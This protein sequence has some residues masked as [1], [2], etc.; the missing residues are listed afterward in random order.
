M[1]RASLA[2]RIFH[3]LLQLSTSMRA[4]PRLPHSQILLT[5]AGTRPRGDLTDAPHLPGTAMTLAITANIQSSLSR[6]AAARSLEAA[7]ARDPDL[8]GLQE[9]YVGRTDML[10]IVGVS[11]WH[12]HRWACESR[13]RDQ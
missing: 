8:L 1:P 2:E 11:T 3:Q 4:A 7:L 5:Y 12:V 13:R 6:A 10:A 9:W